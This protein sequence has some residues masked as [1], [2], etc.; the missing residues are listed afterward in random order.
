MLFSL[1]GIAACDLGGEGTTGER[2]DD[3]HQNERAMDAR[4]NDGAAATGDRV[5]ADNPPFEQAEN[6]SDVDITAEIRQ[7]VLQHPDLGM[8]ADNVTITT[9]GGVVTV[10][11]Q[12]DSA[13]EKA[14][15]VQ[16]A[17][18]VIGVSQVQDEIVVQAAAQ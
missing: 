3:E 15:V 12:V 13:Q 4:G 8:D 1:V 7:Q 2:H 9:A 10:R 17:R 5:E 11:G 18:S 14:I 16:L 6:A